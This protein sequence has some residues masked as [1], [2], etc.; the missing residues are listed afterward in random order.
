MGAPLL[1]PTNQYALECMAWRVCRV[2]Q[3]HTRVMQFW[4]LRLGPRAMQG[5]TA[6]LMLTTLQGPN[7]FY[8]RGFS[9]RPLLAPGIVLMSASQPP[10]RT[11]GLSGHGGVRKSTALLPAVSLTLAKSARRRRAHGGSI[12]SN[13]CRPTS[14]ISCRF[15]RRRVWKRLLSRSCGAAGMAG[16]LSAVGSCED[17]P[18]G[19]GCVIYRR[20]HLAGS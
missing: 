16:L 19:V 5:E 20:L 3:Y 2:S 8:D 9:S 18:A 11:C 13:T 1:Q 14:L 4:T 7:A 6:V 17:A 15:R 10:R 12:F